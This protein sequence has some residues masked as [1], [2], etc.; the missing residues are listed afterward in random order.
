MKYLPEQPTKP[1][2][3]I[4]MDIFVFLGERLCHAPFEGGIHHTY[5]HEI[6]DMPCQSIVRRT[7][8][9]DCRYL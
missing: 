3:A 2:H 8:E 5:P 6:V 7:N 9:V 4:K 1:C